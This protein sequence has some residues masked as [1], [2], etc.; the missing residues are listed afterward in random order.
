MGR[1]YGPRQPEWTQAEIRGSDGRFC[2]DV[3]ESSQT[4]MIGRVS[5]K[6]GCECGELHIQRLS[7]NPQLELFLR[8]SG[9]YRLK[10]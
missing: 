5:D 2:L 10:S 4:G 1:G 6:D 9:E 3:A 7:A 8:S